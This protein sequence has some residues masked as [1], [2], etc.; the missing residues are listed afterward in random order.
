MVS[1]RLVAARTTVKMVETQPKGDPPAQVAVDIS[2]P[3]SVKPG[4]ASAGLTNVRT[5]TT[6]PTHAPV[7]M[8]ILAPT[9]ANTLALATPQLA[10]LTSVLAILRESAK[11]RGVPV[12][13]DVNVP[14]ELMAEVLN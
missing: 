9:V 5:F 2:K 12:A 8:T 11:F 7:A 4:E 6:A 10:T 3:E 14:V 1:A 13:V